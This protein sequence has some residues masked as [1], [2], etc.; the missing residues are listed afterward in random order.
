M[1][2]LLPS[3]MRCHVRH[4]AGDALR[5]RSCISLPP[6]HS[7]PL[8]SV[9]AAAGLGAPRQQD[10]FLR[11]YPACAPL[12]GRARLAP[13][14]FAHLIAR[15]RRRGRASLS[16]ACPGPR[17]GGPLPGFARRFR[18]R[19]G[20]AVHGRPL[21]C[22]MSCHVPHAVTEALRFRSCISSSPSHSVP[23]P[24][25]RSAAR[26]SEAAGPIFARVSCVR[27][28]ARAGAS[29]AGAVRAP[30][31]ARETEDARLPSVPAGAF[32]GPSH[33]FPAQ[34]SRKA[35]PGA[36]SLHP[37]YTTFSQVKPL[38]GQNM[39]FFLFP[40]RKT[41]EWR[42]SLPIYP[43]AHEPPPDMSPASRTPVQGTRRPGG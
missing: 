22:V 39:K 14:R 34:K 35:A 3:V 10:P 5:F 33:C 6:S 18:R 38:G 7:V 20:G 31:C 12:R 2:D 8:P 24:S 4:A 17:S 21:H 36:A 37:S 16:R 40:C 30:D 23:L 1:E 19:A 41:D 27:A 11:A 13:A 29:C 9:R 26:F 28:P 42:K 25:V 15:A 43:I 32:F